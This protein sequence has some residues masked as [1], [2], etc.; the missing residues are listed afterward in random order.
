MKTCAESYAINPSKPYASIKKVSTFILIFAFLLFFAT[1]SNMTLSHEVLISI[2]DNDLYKFSM[3]NAVLKKYKNRDIPVVYQFTNRSKDLRLN[4]ESLKWLQKQINSKHKAKIAIKTHIIIQL[5]IDMEYLK[6][7]KEENEYLSNAKI[8]PYFDSEYINYLSEF[9]FRPQEQV[10]LTFN[11]VNDTFELEVT[12]QWH[13]T[14]L[15]E[16]PL[17]ALI[18]EAYFRFTDRDWD[19]KGQIESADKKA[20]ALIKHGCYFSEFGTRRRRDF[21]TQE[22]VIETIHKV[23]KEYEQNEVSSDPLSIKKG[24]CVGTSNVYLAKKY[25][26]TPIGTVGKLM[27]NIILPLFFFF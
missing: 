7:T 20:R 22:S 11:P 6:L 8:F 13:E 15:Y 16:V 14:I 26:M 1:T 3:Q 12:G 19:Y 2:L 4:S 18:S 24:A 17:L 9:R 10:K 21:K 23:Q 5:Y 27:K 25:N